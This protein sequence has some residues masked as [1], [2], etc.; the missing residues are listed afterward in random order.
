[1]LTYASET[2]DDRGVTDPTTT[3]KAFVEDL[4]KKNFDNYWASCNESIKNGTTR[5]KG[6]EGDFN[7]SDPYGPRK[8][9]MNYPSRPT[10]YFFQD[11]MDEYY[12]W[13]SMSER[14]HDRQCGVAFREI[15]LA[16][17]AGLMTFRAMPYGNKESDRVIVQLGVAVTDYT[18]IR[19]FYNY[20]EDVL[21]ES[22]KREH[23]Y[24][25]FMKD[26]LWSGGFNCFI[27]RVE[28]PGELGEEDYFCDLD[29]DAPTE[30]CYADGSGGFTVSTTNPGIKTCS[31][32]KP[33][34]TR[35]TTCLNDTGPENVKVKEG[36][37]AYCHSSLLLQV[38]LYPKTNLD[39]RVNITAIAF[40]QRIAQPPKMP[41]DDKDNENGV[42]F[43]LD[44][45]KYNS[46]GFNYQKEMQVAYFSEE[47][48]I[49]AR[50][51][52]LLQAGKM[53]GFWMKWENRTQKREGPFLQVGNE[54]ETYPF[55]N[56]DLS[57]G[58]GSG[59]VKSAWTKGWEG[60]EVQQP[61]LDH[62]FTPRFY[63]VQ[64]VENS[65]PLRI[66]LPCPKET[67]EY[68]FGE[69]SPKALFPD[70]GTGIKFERPKQG[71]PVL[72]IAA[73]SIVGLAFL[74]CLGGLLMFRFEKA[75]HNVL[76]RSGTMTDKLARLPFG[77]DLKE[78]NKM[79]LKQKLKEK[80]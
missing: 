67:E 51:E 71:M 59:S 40:L 50:S 34:S 15:D 18:H 46:F 73:A 20:S 23:K 49:S 31:N 30:C 37:V 25:K 28:R 5:M 17:R 78:L 1:M 60:N 54:G 38:E 2:R 22:V 77:K 3:E 57:K 65:R 56:Y 12:S 48:P 8:T 29:E 24:R 10:A 69:C 21:G 27:Q 41:V 66:Q 36:C 26:F 6:H 58:L 42:F 62:T 64:G 11:N 70:P 45:N 4:Y 76:V 9:L 74:V 52:S 47:M 63:S 43:D 44:F 32:F 80:R 7:S 79:H 75:K 53:K 39:G 16:D 13:S 61:V 33:F 19:P 35:G 14:F 68:R 55:V 72:I